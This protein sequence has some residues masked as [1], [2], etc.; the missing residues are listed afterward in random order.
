MDGGQLNPGSSAYLGTLT[1]EVQHAIHRNL[2]RDEDT[3]I[4]EGMSEVARE[5]AGYRVETANPFLMRPDTQL[6]HWPNLL[7]QTG[8]HYGASALF[9]IYLA[10]QYG[11][12]ESMADLSAEQADGVD[13]V[14]AYL[15][16][17]G[18]T[19]LDVFKDWVI[20][21]YLDAPE[22]RLGYPTRGVRVRA[23][24]RLF[25]YGSLNGVLPQFSARYLDIRL[26][27]G[28]ALVTF[29][30]EPIVPQVS[31]TCRSG[32]YCWWGNRGDSIDSTLTREFDLSGLEQATLEFWTWYEIEPTWDHAYVEVSV[33][34]GT[35]WSI[36]EG[37]H[38][39]A[40]DP[41]RSNLGPSFDGRSDGWVKET[42][43]LSPYT[44]QRVLLRFE[45][46][47]DDG[48]Y[49]DGFLIDDLS[50]PE[51]GFEDGA[52]RDMGWD[53]AGFSRVTTTLPQYYAVQVIE[54]TAEGMVTV[55]E[56]SLDEKRRGEYL[57]EGFGD[58]LVSAAIVVSPITLGTHIPTRFSIDVSRP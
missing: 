52:E 36:L 33:D 53:E 30:G 32:R 29:Q 19:F 55:R 35:T 20:A 57:L 6:N 23:V 42:M 13:G 3:W 50:I 4:N 48:V 51:I 21:N 2:D 10:Q 28:D 5:L 47:T 44:G 37:S 45:Y 7:G 34:E 49:L 41:T 31:T 9:L 56:L 39:R 25:D 1:H 43:D 24:Q 14:Q 54:E 27:G 15:E 26:P 12:Y 40:E 17:Y 46:V 38:T 16:P 22:G 58:E 8:R 11:G 18:T